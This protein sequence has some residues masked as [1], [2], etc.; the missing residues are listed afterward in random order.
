MPMA[1]CVRLSYHRVR[2]DYERPCPRY[3]NRESRSRKEIFSLSLPIEARGKPQRPG[4]AGRAA[5]RRPAARQLSRTTSRSKLALLAITAHDVPAGLQCAS[6][7]RSAPPP[8]S[9]R[10]AM[11]IDDRPGRKSGRP[12]RLGESRKSHQNVVHGSGALFKAKSLNSPVTHRGATPRCQDRSMTGISLII[13]RR[14]NQACA[15]QHYR[16]K[17]SRARAGVIDAGGVYFAD[18]LGMADGAGGHVTVGSS[19]SNGSQ[20][21]PGVTSFPGVTPG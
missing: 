1:F 2:Y 9:P 12:S 19:D 8:C 3:R 16:P 17:N 21:Y 6:A 11:R 18:L 14:T 10:T 4:P 5:Y 7:C 20:P 13:L 15:G